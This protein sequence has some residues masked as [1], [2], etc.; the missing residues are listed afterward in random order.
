MKIDIILP[1]YN[2]IPGW[3]DNILSAYQHLQNLAPQFQLRIILVND[4]SSRNVSP[5]DFDKLTQ[6]LPRFQCISYEQNRGKGYAIRQGA[7]LADAPYVVFTDIDFPYL[8]EDLLAVIN[9][10][11]AEQVD[12]VIG[13]RAGNYYTKV[14]I[15][16]V[17]ISK[18]LKL[19]IRT[20]LRVNITDSQGGL[21]GFSQKGL[22]VLK[23]TQIDRYLFD[24]ELIKLASRRSDLNMQPVV[25]NL[26]PHVVFA[27]VG[28]A[29]L[30]REFRNFLKVL[31]MR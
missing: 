1:C 16:R 4:G 9:K 24:L 13:V 27:P 7:A 30:R 25:V 21:K 29:I 14:P 22:D 28:L 8:D 23:S 5:A 6:Q 19:M 26:K 10:L 18:V 20:L 17:F 12:I 11:S 15:W 31:L 3:S 2:P